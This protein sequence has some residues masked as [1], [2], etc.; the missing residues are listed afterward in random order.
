MG[1]ARRLYRLEE[2]SKK[3]DGK[4][5]K[6]YPLQTDMKK[7]KNILK[8]F[9]WTKK[10]VGPISILINNAGIVRK[11]STLI[12]GRTKDWKATMDTNVMGLAI[13]TREAIKSMRENKI[14]GHIIHM[15]SILGKCQCPYLLL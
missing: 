1:I 7:E 13:A 15:N 10:N 14:D 5:G 2:L 4:D 12:E 9:E 6:L 8:A 11:N 3:L